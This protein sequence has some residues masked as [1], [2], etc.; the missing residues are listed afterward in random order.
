MDRKY[1]G[2]EDFQLGNTLEGN[3]LYSLNEKQQEIDSQ[4]VPARPTKSKSSRVATTKHRDNL[5][6]H[7]IKSYSAL[8]EERD[9]ES[10]KVQDYKRL[11]VK[12]SL[13]LHT[14]SGKGANIKSASLSTHSYQ[15]TQSASDDRKNLSCCSCGDF[16]AV[17][18]V[19]VKLPRILRCFHT[20]CTECCRTLATSNRPDN[21]G[22]QIECPICKDVTNL[23][24]SH[25]TSDL[26][27]NFSC[28]KLMKK[29]G[30]TGEQ[31]AQC[32]LCGDANVF[33]YCETCM[34]LICVS[35]VEMH[36]KVKTFRDHKRSRL[37]DSKKKTRELGAPSPVCSHH[38]GQELALW[39]NTCQVSICRDCTFVIHRDHDY[40][41]VAEAVEAHKQEIG[42]AISDAGQKQKETETA[43]DD[44]DSITFELQEQLQVASAAI[45]NRFTEI[46]NALQF[47]Q[48]VIL[49]ELEHFVAQKAE[50]LQH[51]RKSLEIV[52]ERFDIARNHAI[53]TLQYGSSIEISSWVNR[54]TSR[55]HEIGKEKYLREPIETGKFEFDDN[56]PG[57]LE[58]V[59]NYM[60]LGTVG[61]VAY[62]SK[63]VGSGL[64]EA[65]CLAPACIILHAMD[66]DGKARREGGDEVVL[67]FRVRRSGFDARH[68]D[69]KFPI[70]SATVEDNQDGTYSVSYE[71]E[72]QGLAWI[73][74]NVNNYPIEGSPFPLAVIASFPLPKFYRTSPGTVELDKNGR[75]A[76]VTGGTGFHTV[77]VGAP[78]PA[79]GVSF[80]KIRIHKLK[81]NNWCLLGVVG[82]GNP[83]ENSYILPTAYGWACGADVFIGGKKCCGAGGWQGF[84]EG[85]EAV[86]MFYPQEKTLIL[87][88][89]RLFN[90]RFI[91]KMNDVAPPQGYF[92][93]ANLSANGDHI[94]LLDVEPSVVLSAGMSTV[95][96][97]SDP[98]KSHE[99]E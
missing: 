68:D 35:C 54:I 89:P 50:R 34:E 41:F 30:L 58:I 71:P 18:P 26:P 46:I 32:G 45:T 86:F 33:E 42:V 62:K 64:A 29:R 7:E 14:S 84:E 59:N 2:N 79:Q 8:L 72:L 92:L 1:V 91:I 87:T 63:A 88:M 83:P 65:R 6:K 76:R 15:D 5:E 97:S 49:E 36:K 77:T 48:H 96:D 24:K 66:S 78:L 22:F 98:L 60:E 12:L 20:V 21:G 57:L 93:H 44:V 56:V 51:Q 67:D 28:I 85:D 95:A 23:A 25:E 52:H 31:A 81:D 94:E 75:G 80:W 4:Q 47:R 55:V 11:G 73:H 53:R 13:E 19:E 16:F 3:N 9:T 69:E 90:R 40:C 17:P 10:A 43:I 39:C 99:G 61:A 70:K 27:L 82:N 37:G 38:E 74:I